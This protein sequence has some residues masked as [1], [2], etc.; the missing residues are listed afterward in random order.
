MAGYTDFT[1]F[2]TDART[3]GQFSPSAN[4]ILSQ[5]GIKEKITD[6]RIAGAFLISLTMASS[7]DKRGKDIVLCS[8]GLL[9]GYSDIKGVVARRE[10]YVT[11]AVYGGAKSSKNEVGLSPDGRPRTR[12]LIRT[13]TQLYERI[14]DE[15]ISST[16]NPERIK[17]LFEQ[18][19]ANY[20]DPDSRQLLLPAPF[21]DTPQKVTLQNLPLRECRFI[22]RTDELGR[23]TENFGTGNNIQILYGMGGVG[24]TEIA[25]NYAYN[26]RND[27]KA[28]AWINAGSLTEINKSCREFLLKATP[29]SVS[30]PEDELRAAFVSYFETSTDWLI[31]FDNA[32]YLD[33]QNENMRDVLKSYIPNNTGHILITTRCNTDFL[34]AVRTQ[35]EVFSPEIA[36]Q[37]LEEHTEQ[38]ADA[39][40]E[41]LAR[42]LGY[43]PLALQYAASYIREHTTYK[44]YL[45]LWDKT[46]M[47]LFDQEKGHYAE[48][49]V[50]KAF[51]ITLDKI[52]NDNIATDLLQ[53]MAC[54]NVFSLP[55]TDYLEAVERRPDA[56]FYDNPYLPS[57]LEARAEEPQ[58]GEFRVVYEDR[59]HPTLKNELLRNELL[60]SLKR[61]SLISWDKR[62]IS[63]HPLLRE[64]IFDEMN[65]YERLRWYSKTETP[66]ILAEVCGMGGDKDIT[67]EQT[68]SAICSDLGLTKVD[69]AEKTASIICA[70]QDYYERETRKPIHEANMSY[71]FYRVMLL[72]DAELTRAFFSLYREL[73]RTG[74][75]SGS[76]TTVNHELLYGQLSIILGCD[77]LYRSYRPLP[78][79]SMGNKKYFVGSIKFADCPGTL[80]MTIDEAMTESVRAV[81]DIWMDD[82][83]DAR[84]DELIADE[85]SDWWVIALPG[86]K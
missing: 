68:F 40:A 59:L 1:C 6:N 62:N 78:G 67:R 34:R 83:H 38:P 28:V 11:E 65:I 46:G 13:E 66:L 60:Q 49:T 7:L 75:L 22:G 79:C 32:D 63:M 57:I 47:G 81:V 18:A 24:K 8:L 5:N 51:H 77:I 10:K 54:L 48:Q 27:Y 42:K 36:V 64:I 19:K 30:V 53:R 15:F 80:N 25:L 4:V 58:I 52:K 76:P 73:E 85:N 29:G 17:Y 2:M 23:I 86:A 12:K 16:P 37:F 43:L 45:D 31:V 74:G 44:G 35:V 61:Y 33:N 69:P 72:G 55:L 20:I 41:F 82:E 21:Y 71:L 50:R 56:P 70:G 9:E 3:S 26:Q 39:D 14:A 84:L